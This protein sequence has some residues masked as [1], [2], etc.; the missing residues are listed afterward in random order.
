MRHVWSL[1]DTF[2]A[3]D[4]PNGRDSYSAVQKNN[5]VYYKFIFPEMSK[6]KFLELR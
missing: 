5:L 1:D 6:L 3:T 4:A 2:M